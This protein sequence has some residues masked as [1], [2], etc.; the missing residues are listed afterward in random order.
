MVTY[1][2]LKVPFFKNHY[3]TC[4][5]FFR[6]NT[7]NYLKVSVFVFSIHGGEKKNIDADF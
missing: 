5:F 2:I 1:N 3:L 4:Q 7:Y 6:T